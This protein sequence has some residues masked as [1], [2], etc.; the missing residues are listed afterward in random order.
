M[1]P[2]RVVRRVAAAPVRVAR[3]DRATPAPSRLLH[4]VIQ[5]AGML[6][7]LI[8][9]AVQKHTELIIAQAFDLR[10]IPL[11]LEAG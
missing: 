9:E 2:L 1:I 11:L 3:I 10:A 4:H 8:L 5:I 7:A 6:T